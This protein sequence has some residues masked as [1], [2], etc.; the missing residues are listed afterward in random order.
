MLP[1]L[2]GQPPSHRFK[3][4]RRKAY[5]GL[6]SRL[7]EATQ[8]SI[9]K[10]RSKINVEDVMPFR[11][12]GS[13]RLVT[14]GIFNRSPGNFDD[15]YDIVW[16]GR[17]EERQRSEERCLA[18][19]FKPTSVKPSSR[20]G[21]SL[22]R[23]LRYTPILPSG[24]RG[25][26]RPRTTTP[27]NARGGHSPF[28]GSVVSA[29][30]ARKAEVRPQSS[31][32][33]VRCSSVLVSEFDDAAPPS[34]EA[35]HGPG[36][37]K[38]VLLEAE[39]HMGGSISNA[40]GGYPAHGS[41]SVGGGPRKSDAPPMELRSG[42]GATQPASQEAGQRLLQSRKALKATKANAEEENSRSL[43]AVF[44]RK[45]DAGKVHGD[46]LESALRLLGVHKPES[47]RI[48]RA[49]AEITQLTELD[50]EDFCRFVHLYRL[51]LQVE[52]R[53]MFDRFDED[54]SGTVDAAELANIFE[55]VGISP[56]SHVLDEVIQ[57]FDVDG[58]GK[59][60]FEEFEA[61][62]EVL[63]EREGFTRS[64]IEDFHKLFDQFDRNQSGTMDSG[65]LDVAMRWLGIVLNSDEKKKIML[66]VDQDESG[67]IDRTEWLVCMRLVRDQK[68]QSLRNA[69]LK[70]G[71]CKL[72]KSQRGG[73]NIIGIEL[74]ELVRFLGY[75]PDRA[76]MRE[77]AEDAG[78]S[79]VL[80]GVSGDLSDIWRFLKLYR[81]REGLS[82]RKLGKIDVVVASLSD[83]SNNEVHC[84]DIGRA[85]RC[86]GYTLHF[87]R[88]LKLMCDVDIDGSGSID[89][90][91]FRKLVRLVH[92]E[93]HERLRIL[94]EQ[95]TGTIVQDF[96]SDNH[97]TLNGDDALNVLADLGYTEKALYVN[98]LRLLPADQVSS[99]GIDFRGMC[100]AADTACQIVCDQFIENFMF[101]EDELQTLKASFSEYDSDNSGEIE[102]REAVAVLEQAFPAITTDPKER[103]L[104]LQFVR[105]ADK[106][107]DNKFDLHDF[108]RIMRFAKDVVEQKRIRKQ[109]KAISETKF[110]MC[111]VQEFRDL[112]IGAAS[113]GEELTFAD[114]ESLL[115]CI[116]P[117]GA[118]HVVELR[119]KFLSFAGQDE[120][121]QGTDDQLDFGEFL[122]L[123]RAL[124]DE[125]FAQLRERAIVV[126]TTNS[127]LEKK[128]STL[129]GAMEN[130][131]LGAEDR[132]SRRYASKSTA[133]ARK[134]SPLSSTPLSGR[135]RGAFVVQTD[136]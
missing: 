29:A 12:S 109:V 128:R 95:A 106:N 27:G 11:P 74:E 68:L 5:P 136:R 86:M 51:I 24:P 18:G 108:L 14:R 50:Y 92:N 69:I 33:V 31:A 36:P 72:G 64:E 13:G 46:E 117:M 61:V 124:I 81:E 59:L 126:A 39:S 17:K 87:E 118:K 9:R 132:E 129:Q 110:S 10:G 2:H 112:F 133:Y 44:Q 30:A 49:Y 85:L 77:T 107:G 73:R 6:E 121:A 63:L 65:E 40:S 15:D 82:Q 47:S 4:A 80:A 62:M 42:A 91:E 99:G 20:Q 94:F 43:S 57:E 102:G 125:N 101:T 52:H 32:G 104:V 90:F 135:R 71:T 28:R 48:K 70:E 54:K 1:R 75:V 122:W 53:A 115:E 23:P 98:M 3:R 88:M 58:N 79:A 131:V 113:D 25:A 105:E 134:D 38:T 7:L 55:A 96:T 41:F 37:R 83:P 35:S 76:A 19:V 67:F 130:A 16:Y 116:V 8:S 66:D 78:M 119:A 111:E 127:R 22:E 114:I 93:E 100:R 21:S 123:M 26:A 97:A 60:D 34:L 56:M 89:L 120:G 45:A 103:A 84:V